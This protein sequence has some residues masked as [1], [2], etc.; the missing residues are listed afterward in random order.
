[1]AR[2][3][4]IFKSFEEQEEFHKE[5]MRNST[6]EERFAALYRMQQMTKLLHPEKDTTRKITIRKG[7]LE[8]EE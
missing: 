3:I 7:Y 1:M 8:N 6:V 5:Q 4:H 2:S